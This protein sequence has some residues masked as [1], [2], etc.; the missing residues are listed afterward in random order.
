MDC[1]LKLRMS[2]AVFCPRG[3]QGKPK[4]ASGRPKKIKLRTEIIITI[5]LEIKKFT[6]IV[7][8]G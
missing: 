2:I 3:Y 8:K 1:L 7:T 4:K 5:K 6:G